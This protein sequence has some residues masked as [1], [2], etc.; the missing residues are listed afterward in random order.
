LLDVNLAATYY[1]DSNP[2][3]YIS[4]Y[5]DSNWQTSWGIL[6]SNLRATYALLGSGG[7]DT[8][9]VTSWSTFDTNMKN[10]YR[11]YGIDLNT[12][13]NVAG[14]KLI[15]DKNV[16]VGPKGYMYDDGNS[17]IIGRAA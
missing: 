3:G 14:S 5:I 9:W 8:N 15:A 13:V 6:D 16:L 4:S 10:T 2:H 11:L 12:S 17:I 7:I 1:P